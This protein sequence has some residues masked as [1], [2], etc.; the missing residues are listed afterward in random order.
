MTVDITAVTVSGTL[1]LWGILKFFLKDICSG[2]N[3]Y[4]RMIMGWN[5]QKQILDDLGENLPLGLLILIC[6]NGQTA[7][8]RWLSG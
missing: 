1:T 6:L 3:I 2:K 5:R 4:L 7:W 8:L